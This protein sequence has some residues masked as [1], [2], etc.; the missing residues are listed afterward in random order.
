[1]GYRFYS[2]DNIMGYGKALS[3]S[4]NR[5]STSFPHV[6]RMIY[7]EF[8]IDTSQG[9]R[10]NYLNNGEEFFTFANFYETVARGRDIPVFFLGNAFSMV[11]PYFITLGIRIP[12]LQPNKIYKGKAWTVMF[13]RDEQFIESRAQTQFFQATQDTTFFDHAFNNTFYLDT[14]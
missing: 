12:D 14:D 2:N 8:L 10:Q 5:R 4:G 9:S 7:D 1:G 3:V 6:Q 11:N 13:V